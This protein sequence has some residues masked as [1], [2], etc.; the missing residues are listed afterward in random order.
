ME[1]RR[2]VRLQSVSY[3]VPSAPFSDASMSGG[4]VAPSASTL[5]VPF[6]I[7]LARCTPVMSHP[8]TVA[9]TR[10]ATLL[11]HAGSPSNPSLP[12]RAESSC[13]DEAWSRRALARDVRTPRHS[14]PNH[15]HHVTR[16]IRIKRSITVT[17]PTDAQKPPVTLSHHKTPAHKNPLP[18]SIKY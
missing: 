14:F 1:R 4:V 15:H 6:A 17:N 9:A 16:L 2:S 12:P 7:C 18:S 3:E 10:H 13:H 8:G 11:R 5:S